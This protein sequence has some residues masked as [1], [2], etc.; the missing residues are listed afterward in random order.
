MKKTNAIRILDQHQIEYDLVEYQYDESD[1]SVE[2]IAR[3]NQLVLAQVFKTL[4]AKGDK[5]GVFVA[6]VP[7]DSSLDFKL[8]AKATQNKKVRMIPKAEIQGLTGYIRGGCSPLGMKK[9]FPVF[10]DNRANDFERIY[11]N[12]GTKGLLFGINQKDLA[13]VAKAKVLSISKISES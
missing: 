2:K 9:D 13:K 10:I 5:T 7:G 3:D 11:V 1:L 4:V 6:V 8:V 12:A